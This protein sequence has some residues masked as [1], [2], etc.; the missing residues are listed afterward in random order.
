MYALKYG[1]VPVV[2]AVGGLNDTIIQFD[3]KTGKGNGFKYY[4]YG[5]KPLL[6]SIKEAVSLYEN[7]KVWNKLRSE[8]MKY[9][10]S[11]RRSAESYMNLYDSVLKK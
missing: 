2:R 5:T 7:P 10:F 11:W 3:E 4:E 9:D 8:G 6:K 1:S